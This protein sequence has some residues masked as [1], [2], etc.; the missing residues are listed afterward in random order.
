MTQPI[1]IDQLETLDKEI[2]LLEKNQLAIL[3]FILTNPDQDFSKF[4]NEVVALGKKIS[5]NDFHKKL[6]IRSICERIKNN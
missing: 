5:S 3:L 6:I 2:S 4:S 1:T